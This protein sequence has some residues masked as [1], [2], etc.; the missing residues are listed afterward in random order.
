M[1]IILA[2][3]SP[4]RQELMH[5]L[6]DDF[7]VIP[8]DFPE[9]EVSYRGDPGAYCEELA[10][11]KALSIAKQFPSNVILGSDTV[12]YIDGL[13]LNKPRDRADAKAMLEKMQGRE[14]QVL[15]AYA[16]VIKDREIQVVDHVATTVVFSTMSADEIETYLNQEDYMGKAGAY[17]IQGAAAKYVAS[18]DGDFYTV[19]GLPVAKL[20]KEL[21]GLGILE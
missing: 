12:V 4:R 9:R 17:A 3:K 16:I 10:L 15:T 8:S 11:K 20:Y 2:S 18:V 6:T 1:K 19:V 5:F 13:I 21:K 7:V 14:H